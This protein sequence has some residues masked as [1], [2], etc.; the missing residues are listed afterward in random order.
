MLRHGFVCTCVK[1]GNIALQCQYC[2]ECKETVWC[3]CIRCA[4]RRAGMRTVYSSDGD[5]GGDEELVV[6][7]WHGATAVLSFPP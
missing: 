7:R 3:I 4:K 2:A 1:N 6:M 5:G